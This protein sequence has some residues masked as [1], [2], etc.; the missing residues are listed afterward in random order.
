MQIDTEPS[1]D[2]HQNFIMQFEYS[3]QH[4]FYCNFTNAICSLNLLEQPSIFL[5]CPMALQD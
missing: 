5:P 3:F 2:S 4:N 1:R